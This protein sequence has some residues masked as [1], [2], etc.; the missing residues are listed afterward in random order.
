MANIKSAIKRIKQTNKRTMLNRQYRTLLK[1]AVKAV[2]AATS[3]EEKKVA[4]SQLYKKADKAAK[5]GV[6]H[7]NTASRIKSKHSGA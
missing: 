1:L 6:I 3:E 2:K 7:A 5:K 4:V